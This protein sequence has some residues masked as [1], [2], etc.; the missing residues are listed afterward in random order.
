[1]LFDESDEFDKDNTEEINVLF[2]ISLEDLMSA[3][4]KNNQQAEDAGRVMPWRTIPPSPLVLE[5]EPLRDGKTGKGC[6]PLCQ[7]GGVSRV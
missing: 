2:L 5:P 3:T 7:P 6:V 1:M 4:R